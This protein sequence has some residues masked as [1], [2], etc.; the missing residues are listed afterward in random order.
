MMGY[1][2][3]RCEMDKGEGRGLASVLGT[4]GMIKRDER[5][6]VMHSKKS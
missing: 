1:T 2:E 6:G 4:W 5:T 3:K